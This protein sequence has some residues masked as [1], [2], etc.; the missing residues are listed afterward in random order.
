M[1]AACRNPDSCIELKNLQ[2]KHSGSL[3]L[4][5]LDVT[6]D[7]SIAV[8]IQEVL[9]YSMWRGPYLSLIQA[10]ADQVSSK[11][12]YLTLLINAAGLLHIP[13]LLSPGMCCCMLFL[14]QT[15]LVSFMQFVSAE[16]ALSRLESSSLHQVFAVNTFGPILVSK[17]SLCSIL[18][19]IIS[20]THLQFIITRYFMP[21]NILIANTEA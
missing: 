16:T 10:A 9:C 5:Q 14:Q 15:L 17:A 8:R 7:A 4:V 3:Q 21:S 1:V 20:Y 13:D 6:S 19:I 11:H 18:F 12:S 2:S